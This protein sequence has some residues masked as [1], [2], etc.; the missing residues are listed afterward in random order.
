[1]STPASRWV[2]ARI[3]DA[4][5]RAFDQ[6]ERYVRDGYCT[7]DDVMEALLRGWSDEALA[8]AW[9]EHVEEAWS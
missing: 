4:L 3:C 5:A 8:D 7:P 6:I 1:M 9:R 2:D